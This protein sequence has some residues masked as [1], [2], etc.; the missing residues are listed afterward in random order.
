LRDFDAAMA[1]VLNVADLTTGRLDLVTHPSLAVSPLTPILCRFHERYPGVQLRIE[2]ADFGDLALLR[3][4]EVELATTVAPVNAPDLDVND[5][6]VE[7]VVVAMPP[8]SG[9]P[10]GSTIP[11]HEL[12]DMDLI[13]IS[14]GKSL[15]TQMLSERGVS[16]R[17]SVETVHRE[18]VIPLVVGGVGPALMPSGLAPDARMRGAVVCRLDPPLTRQALLVHRRTALSPAAQA[19]LELA[20][21]MLGLA[22]SAVP[23]AGVAAGAAAATR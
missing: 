23:S 11:D 12:A 17:F 14:A 16:P 7:D 9:R 22:S 18:S 19:F 3:S 21:D 1:A 15:L 20:V 8:S 13:V 10:A 4:G 2:S 6:G 5:F